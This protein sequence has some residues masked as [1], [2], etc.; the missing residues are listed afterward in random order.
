[1]HRFARLSEAR[2]RESDPGLDANQSHVQPMLVFG[3]ST[4]TPVV[5]MLS[6]LRVP[7]TRFINQDPKYIW[8]LPR[9]GQD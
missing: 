2:G 3:D 7:A 5:G 9:I 1:M 8:N 6:E 4:K